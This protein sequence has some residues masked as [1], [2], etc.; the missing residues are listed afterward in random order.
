MRA[1]SQS[2]GVPPSGD[3]TSTA[4]A[5]LY[6][7]QVAWVWNAL[8]RL[9]APEADLEDLAHEVFVA[10]HDA[11]KRFDTRRPVRPWLLGISFRVLSEFRRHKRHTTEVPGEPAQELIGNDELEAAVAERQL[12]RLLMKAVGMLEPDRRAVFV[13][14]DLE[15]MP[16]PQVAEALEIPL[17]TAYSRLRLARE[18]LTRALHP[19]GGAS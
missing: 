12:R 7:G 6:Q 19:Q 15:E 11:L 16:M 14:H 17:N 5:L 1:P 9:G 8:R 10:A 18:S 4:F 3:P 13:A 2:A